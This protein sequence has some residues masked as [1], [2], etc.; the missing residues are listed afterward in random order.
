MY[1]IHDRI[2][3][4]RGTDH[5]A[6]V[7]VVKS[8]SDHPQGYL[9]LDEACSLSMW[10]KCYRLSISI[11]QDLGCSPGTIS[12]RPR[13]RRVAQLTIHSVL[14][15]G[16]S[17]S[18]A[19]AWRILN[20]QTSHLPIN[21]ITAAGL[22]YRVVT[23]QDAERAFCPQNRIKLVAA[24][25]QDLESACRRVTIQGLPSTCD[26]LRLQSMLVNRGLTLTSPPLVML[27]KYS[28]GTCV[29]YVVFCT[30]QMAFDAIVSSPSFTMDHLALTFKPTQPKQGRSL[31]DLEKFEADRLA[32]FGASD[33]MTE[34]M[35]VSLRS[36]VSSAMP[37]QLE[38]I[39]SQFNINAAGSYA[40]EFANA[41]FSRMDLMANKVDAVTASMAVLV[42]QQAATNSLH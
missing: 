42:T 27:S 19:L 1:A 7:Q 34:G 30:E 40:N 35:L 33:G 32:A 2:Y 15:R 37:D 22:E 3:S 25:Q 39:K 28:P 23:F 26:A 11:E 5:S 8:K 24:A 14:V 21:F 18:M 36:F 12:I 38:A 13:Y 4:L 16:R 17:D 29:A 41:L 9:S 31:A 6:I 10:R 20:R